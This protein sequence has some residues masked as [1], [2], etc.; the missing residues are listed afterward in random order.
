MKSLKFFCRMTLYHA[1]SAAVY[2]FMA[3]TSFD[4][5][6]AE[7]PC[8]TECSDDNAT[9]CMVFP[10]SEHVCDCHCAWGDVV[11]LI[12]DSG[13]LVDRRQIT[14]FEVPRDFN[15]GERWCSLPTIATCRDLLIEVA[16]VCKDSDCYEDVFK[17]TL[18]PFNVKIP[19]GE[20]KTIWVNFGCTAI[21]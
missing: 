20:E 12:Y 5:Q 13:E 1:I 2:C 18:S 4:C 17:A 19:C 14:G 9:L 16:L 21:A 11:I 10:P 15:D 8:D 3:L 7:D 6:P